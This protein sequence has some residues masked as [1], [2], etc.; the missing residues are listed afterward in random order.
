[1]Q[2]LTVTDKIC[3]CW[4]Q[5]RGKYRE[6][7]WLCDLILPNKRGGCRCSERDGV[8]AYKGDHCIRKFLAH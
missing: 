8:G 3:G 6:R 5:M 2:R 7:N 1:M 4:S